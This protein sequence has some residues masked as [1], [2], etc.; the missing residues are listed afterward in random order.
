[1]KSGWCAAPDTMMGRLLELDCNRAAKD[2]IA[3]CVA[4]VLERRAAEH[5]REGDAS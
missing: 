5:P 4:A 1:M 3:M 2:A